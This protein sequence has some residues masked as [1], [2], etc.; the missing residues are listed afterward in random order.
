MKYAQQDLLNEK[1]WDKFKGGLA[2]GKELVKMAVPK[3]SEHMGK[4]FDVRDRLSDV[5][6]SKADPMGLLTSYVMDRG[7]YPIE[8]KYKQHKSKDGHIVYTLNVSELNYDKNGNPEPAKGS[9]QGFVYSQ[10]KMII[11]YDPRKNKL[12]TLKS[13]PKHTG[14]MYYNT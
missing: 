12:E 5:Y 2:L 13:P 9:K 8:Q 14:Q 3:A 1:F 4:L 10:P 7:Y 6:K 11:K